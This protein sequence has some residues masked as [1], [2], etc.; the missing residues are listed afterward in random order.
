ME[1]EMSKEYSP[2]IERQIIR[3]VINQGLLSDEQE[4][5]AQ[6]DEEYERFLEKQERKALRKKRKSNTKNWEDDYG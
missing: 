5:Q 6:I 2:K 1:I 4:A 3:R